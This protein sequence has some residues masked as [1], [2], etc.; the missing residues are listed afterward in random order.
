[1]TQKQILARKSLTALFLELPESI[2]AQHQRIVLDALE[3]CA[4]TKQQNTELTR[5]VNN[6]KG[7]VF[8]W[9]WIY[10]KEG[11]LSP[12][13][14]NRWRIDCCIYADVANSLPDYE[15]HIRAT[16]EDYLPVVVA[17]ICQ[18][19]CLPEG[20]V[21][22]T[23]HRFCAS[24]I[25]IKDAPNLGIDGKWNFFSDN[26]EELKGIVEHEINNARKLFYY[27]KTK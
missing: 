27:A 18:K 6:E 12:D 24:I 25:S 10:V 4:D 7:L 22:S 20:G 1:M 5:A 15:W 8:T 2:A 23:I 21:P 11:D 3:E 16:G 13:E 19:G 26:I 17:R 9:D 14:F